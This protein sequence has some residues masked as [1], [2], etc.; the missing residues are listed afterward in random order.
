M[1][2]IV[3]YHRS[4]SEAFI[5]VDWMKI[6]IFMFWIIFYVRVTIVVD[7]TS[8]FINDNLPIP[9]QKNKLQA[10]ITSFSAFFAITMQQ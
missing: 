3:P 8:R 10:T 5:L 2:G 9:I 4:G 6:F 7:A 1:V